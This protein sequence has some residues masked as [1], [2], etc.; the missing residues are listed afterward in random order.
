MASG[1]SPN[2]S[3]AGGDYYIVTS[4]GDFDISDGQGTRTWGVGD[5]I[6]YKL[7]CHQLS[8]PIKSMGLEYFIFYGIFP[9]FFVLRIKN[10]K[11]APCYYWNI[12]HF[13]NSYY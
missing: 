2:V 9:N 3:P 8:L 4:G 7:E 11:N 5:W 12:Y 6:V 10:N 13:F 1:T